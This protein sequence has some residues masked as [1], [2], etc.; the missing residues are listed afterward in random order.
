MAIGRSDVL[1]LALL[2]SLCLGILSVYIFLTW[3]HRDGRY[4]HYGYY[5]EFR[6]VE[7]A[8]E[9]L[10]EVVVV[11][12]WYHEDLTLEEFGFALDVAG[13]GRVKM[14]F[15]EDDATRRLSGVALVAALQRRVADAEVAAMP[16]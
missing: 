16:D 9:T 3:E 4:Y 7:S 12:S 1:G 11:D 15:W 8:L 6:K 10:P 5:D 13:R 2:A 14:E